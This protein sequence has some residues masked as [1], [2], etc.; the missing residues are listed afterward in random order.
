MTTDKTPGEM[1]ARTELPP[2]AQATRLKGLQRTIVKQMIPDAR[3][4]MIDWTADFEKKE[5][6]L[7]TN[8]ISPQLLQCFL[9]NLLR[10][11][12]RFRELGI[13]DIVQICRTFAVRLCVMHGSREVWYTISAY[14]D[15][16]LAGPARAE[17]EVVPD[18][19]QH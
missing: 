18:L 7:C 2:L 3:D 16:L 10:K 14:R 19:R 12:E 6:L 15:D 11:D 9:E 13:T 17:I 5:I 8:I 1:Q 4:C